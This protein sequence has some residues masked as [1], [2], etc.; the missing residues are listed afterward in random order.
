MWRARAR[1]LGSPAAGAIQVPARAGRIRDPRQRTAETTREREWRWM[2]QAFL[3]PRRPDPAGLR[4]DPWEPPLACGR[5]YAGRD[6]ESNDWHRVQIGRLGHG[7]GGV[8]NLTGRGAGDP[9]PIR[10][11]ARRRD[12]RG[13]EPRVRGVR[14]SRECIP[15]SP[16]TARRTRGTIPRET[17]AACPVGGRGRPGSCPAIS[18]AVRI[19]IVDGT[20]P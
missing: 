2:R 7:V 20:D 16:R 4:A 3:A 8:C 18:R 6:R 12:R 11:G 9:L 5:L 14:G 19:G 15:I 17:A 13:G 1:G 10:D